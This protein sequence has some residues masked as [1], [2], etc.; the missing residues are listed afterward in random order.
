MKMY[1]CQLL[2]LWLLCHAIC[3]YRLIQPFYSRKK[4]VQLMFLLISSRQNFKQRFILSQPIPSHPIPSYIILSHL[5]NAMMPQTPL[6]TQWFFAAADWGPATSTPAVFPSSRPSA[7]WRPR[8]PPHGRR[9]P[10]AGR[11]ASRSATGAAPASSASM[12]RCRRRRNTT[13]W[14]SSARC[15]STGSWRERPSIVGH[16]KHYRSLTTICIVIIT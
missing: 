2:L 6:R 11:T 4:A 9:R 15:T 8:R 12:S 13:S 10:P 16:H 5:N 14:A 7:W 1:V 3:I